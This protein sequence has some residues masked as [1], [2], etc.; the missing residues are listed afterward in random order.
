M[1]RKDSFFKE[2]RGSATVM[3]GI[4]M[5]VFV[6]LLAFVIDLAHVQ[7]V[8]TELSNAA[9]AAALAGARVLMPMTGPGAPP[10]PM[11]IPPPCAAAVQAALDTSVL[12]HV[13]TGP[14]QRNITLDPAEVTVGFWD[15]K[16]VGTKAGTF[17]PTACDGTT[18]AV[19]VTAR[20]SG[21]LPQGPVT[22]TL[23]RIFGI[24]TVNPSATAIAAIG[25]L[26]TL[27]KGSAGGFLASDYDYLQKIYDYWKKNPNQLFYL[28]LSPAGGQGSYEFADNGGWALPSGDYKSF[29]PTVNDYITNGTETDISVGDYVD[30]KNGQMANLV[31]SL[32]TAVDG[33]NHNLDL[34]IEGVYADALGASVGD[35]WNEK[36]TRV[37]SFWDITLTNVWKSN[38]LNKDPNVQNIINA[39]YPDVMQQKNI[40]G[41]IEFK[42]RGPGAYGGAGGNGLPSNTYGF[43]VKLV[44]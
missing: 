3:F 34:A 14:K 19:R 43:L 22:M 1:K 32:Q 38:E 37:D 26:E 21:D 6:G 30:L 13:D 4:L 27:P 29:N 41:V 7:N 10:W 23:A 25:N 18:N 33:A 2:S 5:F 9:D 42:M 44:Q 28:V 31:K 17:T 40:V 24:N 20:M 39:M 8:K 16:P 36:S 12:N 11:Q 35:V 15:Y